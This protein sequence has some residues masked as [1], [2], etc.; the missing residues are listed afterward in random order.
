MG[1]YQSTSLEAKIVPLA[2][3]CDMEQGRARI[4]YEKG[5]R[6]MH[7]LSALSITKVRV[8]EGKLNQ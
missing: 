1:N 5:K 8:K 3:G 4:P 7:G 6:D 2:D